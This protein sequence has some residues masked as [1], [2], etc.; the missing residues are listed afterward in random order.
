M[1]SKK[2]LK[3]GKRNKRNRNGKEPSV[4]NLKEKVAAHW[5][6]NCLRSFCEQEKNKRHQ[7]FKFTRLKQTNKNNK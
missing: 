2:K 1:S 4:L 3:V 7:N 6:S 5:Q